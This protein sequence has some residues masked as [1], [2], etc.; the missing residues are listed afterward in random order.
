MEKF[1]KL[2]L[3]LRYYLQGAADQN[4]DY[5][6]ALDAFEFAM[7]RH[8]GLRKD[9]VTPEFQHQ[10]ETTQLTRT[11]QASLQYPAKTLA[12]MLLHDTAEDYDVDFEELREKFG[13]EVAHAVRRLTKVHRGIK[14]TPQQYFEE[15]LDCPIA[16]VCKGAD[17]AHNQQSMVGVFT[18]EKQVAYLEE[19]TTWILPMLKKARR[20]HPRQEAAYENLKFL[21]KSQ[22]DLIRAIHAAEKQ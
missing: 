3:S 16:T 22:V 21:L 7:A 19:T 8:T 4:S 1:E 20:R 9:G 10:L 12:A 6:I 18:R 17:R 15:M 11:L 5:V 2:R 13:S 14:L